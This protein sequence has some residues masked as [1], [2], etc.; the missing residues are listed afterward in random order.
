MK[1]EIM[2]WWRGQDFD[3][4][5][6]EHLGN[7]VT[8]WKKSDRKLMTIARHE[9]ERFDFMRRME[10]EHGFSGPRKEGDDKPRLWF[11]KYRT[12]DDIIASSSEDFIEFV[13]YMPELQF[14]LFDE[15][16]ESNGCSESCEVYSD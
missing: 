14:G 5:L 3:L 8:C 12:C 6:P 2:H 13:D 4:D 9:P 10:Q 1:P 15:M 11:R 16:D 7:C